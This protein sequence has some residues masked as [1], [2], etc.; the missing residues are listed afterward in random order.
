MERFANTGF[1]SVKKYGAQGLGSRDETPSIQ[2]TIDACAAGGGGVV[3]IPPGT[4]RTGTI[5]LQSRVTLLVQ[6]GATVLYS[7]EETD[8]APPRE[9]PYN[10][11]ADLETSDFDFALLQGHDLHDVT[12]AGAGAIVNEVYP[13][14]GPKPVAL[15]G[16]E[17]VTIRDLTIRHAP[18]YA[19]SLLD[20]TRV[21][22]TGVHVERGQADGIDLDNCQHARVT[23]CHVD[24]WDDG[25]CLKTSLAAGEAG[26][27]R[28]VAI[29]NCVV[30]SSCNCVKIG[31]ETSGDC[32]HV[33]VSNCTFFPRPLARKA[34][35]GLAVESADGATVRAVTATNLA[36]EDVR[37]PVFVTVRNRGRGQDP[38]MP[39]RVQDVV[40]SNVTATGAQF[41]VTIA[42]LPG[43]PVRAVVLRDVIVEYA[44]PEVKHEGEII[45]VSDLPARDWLA[46]PVPEREGAY[47]DPT[48]LGPLPAWGVYCRH[49]REVTLAR[50][51]FRLSASGGDPRPCVV[52][53][54]AGAY[55]PASV[56]V[57]RSASARP[58]G[59]PGEA[60]TRS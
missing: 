9:L 57:A 26:G 12:L 43:R 52:W 21:S 49:A 18:N 28:H 31:T 20:C 33:A 58:A 34:I 51:R 16:C 39:G 10:P 60:V 47:P 6:Q 14:G 56:H 46:T 27:T 35:A 3:V 1:V 55:D 15:R 54:D 4:Y 7:S 13:R 53:E 59:L 40:V 5:R 32:T 48:M 30:G 38:P 42:G 36:M 11:H 17:G 8:F 41:P 2:A 23:N 50:C 25:I 29:A 22:I 37:C 19:V 24:A 45:P 44:R